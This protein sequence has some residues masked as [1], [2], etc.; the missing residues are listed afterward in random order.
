MAD[1]VEVSN[2]PTSVNPDIPVRTIDKGGEQVQV[3]AVDYG[4]A[5]AED[6]TVP[7]FAT[8]NTL[9]SI[10]AAIAG[11]LYF[12]ITTNSDILGVSVGGRRNN[13]I[14]LSF[15]DSFDNNLITNTTAA[16][17][18]ATISGGHARYRTGANRK[19]CSKRRDSLQ[20]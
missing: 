17:G 9:Q 5:G 19:R 10:N 15:F 18:S 6:L 1:N 4:G 13:E 7:D 14:E 2:S 3:V 12:N 20:M 16:G 8:E 11:G